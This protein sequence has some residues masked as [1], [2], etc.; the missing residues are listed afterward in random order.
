MPLMPR[1]MITT[2]A[3]MVWLLSPSAAAQEPSVVVSTSTFE[4]PAPDHV[5]TALD[6]AVVDGLADGGVTVVAAPE[7]CAEASCMAQA[8]SEGLALGHGTTSVRIT[9]SDYSLTFDILDGD[10]Q[11]L[12]H[13]EGSCEICTHEEAAVALRE[14]VA[15]AA[16]ELR[17]P[18]EET[19]L[20]PVVT[21][22]PVEAPRRRMSPRTTE[23]IAWSA[24]G[25]G[26][27]ALAGGITLLVLDQNPVKSNCTGVHVDADGDCE[28]RYDTLGGG[29]GLTVAGAVAAGAGVGLLLYSRKQRDRPPQTEVTLVPWGLRARF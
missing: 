13:R 3:A 7:G 4:E 9:G 21:S 16:G 10:G 6:Q 19:S 25:V 14:L 17:P 23:I 28:F 12:A 24:I 8:V 1:W 15:A 20:A 22:D 5:S 29:I 11:S 18:P 27:A 2:A 26:V